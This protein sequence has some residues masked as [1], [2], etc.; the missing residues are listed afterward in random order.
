MLRRGI[1]MLAYLSPW[2][3]PGLPTFNLWRWDTLVG[4]AW[5][6]VLLALLYRETS[7]SLDPESV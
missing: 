4:I 5:A 7:F 6:L 3:W 1:Q 2:P